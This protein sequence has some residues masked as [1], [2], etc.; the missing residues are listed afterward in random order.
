MQENPALLQAEVD[1]ENTANRKRVDETKQIEAAQKAEKPKAENDFDRG[2][3]ILDKEN[4]TNE[5]K[6]AMEKILNHSKR[7]NNSKKLDEDD[8]ERFRSMLDQWQN[9]IAAVPESSAG[10]D[11]QP[12]P[13]KSPVQPTT[14]NSVQVNNK[15]VNNTV[16]H[17]VQRTDRKP[18][19]ALA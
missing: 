8:S 1:K 15:T 9:K 11:K 3:Q 5:D 16:Q 7:K 17:S 13:V 4:I 18:L 6:K 2:D 10:I 14:P 19:I 12:E